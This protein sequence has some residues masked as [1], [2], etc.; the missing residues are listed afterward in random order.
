MKKK[1]QPKQQEF[2]VFSEHGYFSGLAY[3]GIPQWSM[4]PNDAKPLNHM[5]KFYTL[6]SIS[7][8][9]LIFEFI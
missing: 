2:I 5:N 3:G 9:E 4:N 1:K 8:L 7:Y 6:Q